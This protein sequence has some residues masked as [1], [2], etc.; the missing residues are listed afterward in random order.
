[1]IS[2]KQPGFKGNK[3][4]AW[5]PARPSQQAGLALL[6]EEPAAAAL[7]TSCKHPSPIVAIPSGCGQCGKSHAT[8]TGQYGPT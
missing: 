3:A 8:T 6:R 2:S 1:M 5:C 7:H 4:G